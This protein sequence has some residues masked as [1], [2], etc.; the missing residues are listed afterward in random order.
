[1]QI[2]F[3]REKFMILETKKRQN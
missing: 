3:E 1:V 2:Q